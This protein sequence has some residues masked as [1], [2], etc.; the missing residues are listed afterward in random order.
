MKTTRSLSW[1]IFTGMAIVGLLPLMFMALGNYLFSQKAFFDSE[2]GHLAYALNSRLV[3]FNA[4]WKHTRKE[5]HF[6]ALSNCA[7][8]KCVG[9][10][11]EPGQLSSCNTLQSLARGHAS[12]EEMGVYDMNWDL[13]AVPGE[14]LRKEDIG[15]PS[16]ELK[17]LLENALDFVI[18]KEYHEHETEKIILPVGQPAFLSD[19]SRSAYLVAKLDVTRSLER[20]FSDASDIGES[21][22]IFLLSQEGNSLWYPDQEICRLGKKTE[23]P[24]EL[25]TDTFRQI[26]SYQDRQGKKVIGISEQIPELNWV[27]VLQVDSSEAFRWLHAS[28]LIGGITFLLSL[29]LIGVIAVR[30]SRSL[31]EPFQELARVARKIS[32]G[33]TDERVPIFSERESQ[34]VAVAFNHMLDRIESSKKI[35]ARTA[36]LASV[37]ELSSSIVH[38]MRNPLSSVKMNLQALSRKV[39]NDPVYLEMADIAIEQALRLETMLSDLLSYGKPLDLKV[40]GTVFKTLADNVIGLLSKEA[41][42][43]GITIE[44]KDHLG[45]TI[46]FVD[47]E[48]IN[49]TLINLI[50]NAIYWAPEDSA[51]RIIGKKAENENSYIIEVSDRGPGIREEHFAK[52]FMPFFT[53]RHGGTG[54]GLANVRKIVEMHGGTVS[55]ENQPEGGAVFTV[56]I[57]LRIET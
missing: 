17:K 20:I 33:M 27:L 6:A 13:I 15:Q 7:Q 38:E 53:T 30:S 23:V 11:G 48:L 22:K 36:S 40:E 34:E 51:I 31:S 32:G 54:L 8:K 18:G 35:L 14:S 26:V 42:A 29:V 25:Y 41:G 12:Y 16:A 43:K 37:G 24:S 49:R 4:W 21:G 3:W 5:F 47:R 39:E 55:A 1:K 28:M 56:E 9:K 10:V 2:T 57:P 19:G 45:E 44:A 46:L 52:M 50:K